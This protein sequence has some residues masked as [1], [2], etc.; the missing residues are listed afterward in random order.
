MAI[1]LRKMRMRA[2]NRVLLVFCACSGLVL[3]EGC[4]KSEESSEKVT[5]HIG[6]ILPMTG[7]AGQYGKWVQQGMEIGRIEA[8]EQYPDVQIDITYE[9]SQADPKQAVSAFHKLALGHTDVVFAVTSGDSLAIAPLSTNY[10]I[11]VITGTLVPGITDK[12]PL[13]I[14]N[15]ANMA[16]ETQVMAQYLASRNPKPRVAVVYVNNDV[17]SF[18]QD[19]FKRLYE[20]EGG[21]VTGAE[22]Y[23]PGATDFRPQLTRL[24][25]ANPDVLYFLSYS[26]WATI[27]KQARELGMKC[28]FAGAT[29]TE[30][31]KALEIAGDVANG[32][33]YTRAAFDPNADD[34]VVKEFQHR[35]KEKY[36]SMAEVWAATFRD[37]VLLVARAASEGAKMGAELIN[38]IV[39]FK[40]Y[41]GASGETEF[42]ANRDTNKPVSIYTIMQG[43]FQPLGR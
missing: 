1:V 11:P 17:G 40:T 33:I 41:H 24:A 6:A 43:R 36:G 26:E 8:K 34:P 27:E 13:L 28:D 23:P 38:T 21:T 14:R 16:T 15:G 20:A 18:S 42:L 29:P 32:T 10:D 37:N 31:A 25:Q 4:R 9:D 30:D 3:S 35:Y 19:N 2:F 5:V 22:A 12:S 39:S 7:P